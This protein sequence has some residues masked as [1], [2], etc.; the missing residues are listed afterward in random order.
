MIVLHISYKGNFRD[1]GIF[2]YLKELIKNQQENGYIC[3]WLTT[4]NISNKNDFLKEITKIR[5]NI[6]HIHGIWTLGTRLIFSLKKITEN[7]IVSPH[8]MLNKECLKQSY[9]KK[10]IYFSLFEKRALNKIK[11]F[12]ALNKKE[13]KDIK[14]LFPKKPIKIIGHGQNIIKIN[15]NNLKVNQKLDNILNKNEKI[16]LFIGRLE[17]Q[18]GLVELIE[19][20]GKIKLEAEKKGWW[21]L[22]AGFGSLSN[23]IKNNS[24]VIDS[25]IIFN[26]V[27]TGNEKNFILQKC[28]ALILPSFGEGLPLSILEA[29]SFKTTCLISKFCNYDELLSSNIAL[30]LK[31]SRKKI[32]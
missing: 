1:G 7:I 17:P 24:K 19:A 30:E 31:L 28:S 5:P 6:I 12:H 9:L 10:L 13:L 18:K 3:Y 22:I 4:N 14:K 32:T 25:R 26:G 8:G 16:L 27:T 11:Y 2:Y 21:L 15:Q 29:L 23:M 20:W